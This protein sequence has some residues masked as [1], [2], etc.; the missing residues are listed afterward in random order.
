MVIVD[1]AELIPADSPLGTALE[2]TLRTGR[3]GEHGLI[4]G[5]A[6]GD[7]TSAYRGS[8]PRPASPAPA[9][10]WRC[11]IPATAT[12]SPYGSR[13]ARSAALP[14]AASWSPWARSPR[15]RRPCPGE[16]VTVREHSPPG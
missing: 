4:I 16:R 8:S 1:D 15:S 5:G 6:T 12:C 11:R 7:L 13:A 2:R 10:C 14:V 9:C 3:D